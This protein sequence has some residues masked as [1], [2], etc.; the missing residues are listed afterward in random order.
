MGGTMAVIESFV[1]AKVLLVIKGVL[2]SNPGVGM[3]LLPTFFNTVWSSGLVP[4][5]E[6]LVATLAG[7]GALK[8]LVDAL[9]ALIKAIKNGGPGKVVDALDGVLGAVTTIKN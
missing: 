6:G 7:I 5:L 1:T 2:A 8:G 9:E 4:A 3:H